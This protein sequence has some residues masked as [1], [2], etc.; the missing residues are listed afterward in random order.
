[1]F[2]QIFDPNSLYSYGTS[3]MLVLG[4]LCENVTLET[5]LMRNATPNTRGLMSSSFTACGYFGQLMFS[6]AGG[7][8][9]DQFG[10][11]VPFMLV[12]C[13]D[14]AFA[15]VCIFLSCCGIIQNDIA[16]KIGNSKF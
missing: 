4:T 11:K 1:M 15:L 14:L 8:L 3:V 13:L 5:V 2:T 10:P 16:N 6:L 9:F 12:G 7:I